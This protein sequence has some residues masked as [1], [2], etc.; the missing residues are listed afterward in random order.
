M[1]TLANNFRECHSQA[2]SDFLESVNDP[3]KAAAD[4]LETLRVPLI[5]RTQGEDPRI[6]LTHCNQL[7]DSSSH[8][9]VTLNDKAK[10]GIND[11]VSESQADDIESVACGVLSASRVHYIYDLDSQSQGK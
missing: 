3:E 10:M 8:A 7:Y 5:K 1:Q 11:L 4:L 6:N 2:Y 9:N